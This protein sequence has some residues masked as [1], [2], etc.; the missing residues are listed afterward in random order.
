MGAFQKA[1]KHKAFGRVSMFGP[2]GSGKTWS[3][4]VMA[5]V[6]RGDGRV[7]VIDTERGSSEKYADRFD[8]D[9]LRLR[10]YAP[11]DFIDAIR[12]AAAEKYPVLII[13]SLSHAWMGEGGILDQADKAGGRFDAW[14]DLTP[15]HRKLLAAI[16]DYPGHVIA[17]MRSKMDYVIEDHVNKR[18]ETVKTPRKVGLAPVQKDDTEYEFDVVLALDVRNNARVMKSRCPAFEMDKSLEKI[19]HDHASAFLKWLDG[20]EPVA[21]P[22]AQPTVSP[23]KKK[24]TEALNTL[25]L[26]GEQRDKRTLEALKGRKPKSEA[27]LQAILAHLDDEIA[28][29]ANGQAQGQPS[30]STTADE[31]PAANGEQAHG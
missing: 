9:V 22:A 21:K 12:D 18:G 25:G 3:A 28:E 17:T 20:A 27:D 1:I 8:F 11:A 23:T 19:T 5:E 31:A 14:K 15:Q 7:A 6:L 13:D 4:Q 30:E 26:E 10:R 2:P 29:K 24:I 16:L